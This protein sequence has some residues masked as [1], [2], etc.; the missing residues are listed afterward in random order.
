MR[1]RIGKRRK[2]QFTDKKHPVMGII[3]TIIAVLVFV[4]ML[5]L[6]ISSGMNGGNGGI[7]YG[8]L[9]LLNLALAVVGFV[10]ALRCYRKEDI[11]M[12]TPAVGSLVN[13]GIIIIYLI[14]YI[15]G[16]L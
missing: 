10:I 2:I 15:L 6:F 12:T 3:S 9:G 14:L 16:V 7:I 13:G 4:L 1:V 5:G 8:Y 11:Y